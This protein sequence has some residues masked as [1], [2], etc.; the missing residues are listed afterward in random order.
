MDRKNPDPENFQKEKETIIN[1]LSQSKKR[2]TFDTWLTKVRAA[3][4][5]TI[6]ESFQ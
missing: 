6:E 4:D 2:I 5:I 1:R 3:S